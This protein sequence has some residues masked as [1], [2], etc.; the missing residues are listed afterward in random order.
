VKDLIVGLYDGKINDTAGVTG[1]SLTVDYDGH[2]F[3]ESATGAMA[4]A[5]FNDKAINLGSMASFG[6][7][8][9]LS[10][11]LS[12]TTTKAGAGFYGDVIVGDP[13]PPTTSAA[14][15]AS[16]PHAT[17]A[18]P[19]A[20]AVSH[21]TPPAS[22]SSM[23]QAMATFGADPGALSGLQELQVGEALPNGLMPYAASIGHSE[24]H[25]P[26]FGTA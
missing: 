3:T 21:P 16:H 14:A 1:I 6:D 26:I 22:V 24:R 10:I 18:Q 23:I 12:V 17:G 8:L 19:S 13:P 7:T 20:A 2:S 9:N 4:V 15:T 5:A 11:S 25:R